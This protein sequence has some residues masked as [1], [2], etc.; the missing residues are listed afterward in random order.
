MKAATRYPAAR[1]ALDVLLAL[2]LLPPALVLGAVVAVAV[3]IDSPGPL[4][5]RA[6]RVGRHG[7]P[8]DML[9]FRTMRHPTAGPRIRWNGDER[10]TPFGR[11]LNATRLDELPQLWNVLKGDM[12]LVGPRPE[13]EQFVAAQSQAYERILVVPPGLTGPTQLQ[14]ADEGRLLAEAPDAVRAYLDEVLPLKVYLDLE[15]VE[16]N[17]LAGDLAALGR[18]LLLPLRMVIDRAVAAFDSRAE[19]RLERVQLLAVTTGA[20]TLP[21]AF[22]AQGSGGL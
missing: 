13:D 4:L 16:S 8:F 2:L 14:F 19:S 9:K 20:L 22:V 1:R 11:L 10:Q 18:T 17:S 6:R 3:L 7:V 12:A 15:Y 21:V 5:Y